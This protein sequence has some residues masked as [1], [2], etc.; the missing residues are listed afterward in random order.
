MI[1]GRLNAI[2]IRFLL[3]VLAQ[4]GDI[5]GTLCICKTLREMLG[6]QLRLFFTHKINN[7]HEL[8]MVF[9]NFIELNLRLPQ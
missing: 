5:L 8:L 4:S 3:F 9:V 7:F 1:F 2:F 6:N